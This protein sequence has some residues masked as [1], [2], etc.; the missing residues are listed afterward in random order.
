MYMKKGVQKAFCFKKMVTLMNRVKSTL[1]H[2]C[3]S[4]AQKYRKRKKGLAKY[5]TNLA[6]CP[7][8]IFQSHQK[9]AL[10]VMAD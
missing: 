6:N 5:S 7:E 4:I 2:H 9:K 1:V 8:D 3:R 10:D